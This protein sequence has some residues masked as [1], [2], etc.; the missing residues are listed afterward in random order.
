[1]VVPKPD[2]QAIIRTLADHE[3]DF[4]IVGGISAVLH[5]APIATFDLDIVHSRESGNLQRL[6]S[7]LERLGAHYREHADK[8]ICPTES[9][10]DS[11]GHHL[12]MTSMGPLDLIG[13]VTRERGY[14]DLLNE[15]EMMTVG[16]NLNVR[17]LDLAALIAIKEE[18]GQEK[19]IAALPVLRRTLG[20]KNKG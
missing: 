9:H 8:R 13:A 10:L 1:M 5:G 19:D 6:I 2:F 12:L 20:E 16:E 14:D 4:I 3:V 17:V 15:S 11:G 18:L 7:A